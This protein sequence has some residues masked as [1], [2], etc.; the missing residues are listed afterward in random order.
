M[1]GSHNDTG[2]ILSTG[3]GDFNPQRSGSNMRSST[4]YPSKK[5]GSGGKIPPANAENGGQTSG[6]AGS[7]GGD[8]RYSSTMK[9]K[10]G[11]KF[12]PKGR[13][14]YG[15]NGVDVGVSDNY[16]TKGVSGGK[17]GRNTPG[18]RAGSAY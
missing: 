12:I 13:G 8:K 17:A 16:A 15:V 2:I 10:S 9:G 6:F 5:R 7:R 14:Q 1:K 3:T 11:G 18:G 4:S